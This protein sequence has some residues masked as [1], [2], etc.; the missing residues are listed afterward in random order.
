MGT[1]KRFNLVSFL[2]AL[3]ITVAGYAVWKTHFA[4]SRARAKVL[5]RSAAPMIL[6]H[7]VDTET[8]GNYERYKATQQLLA[9]SRF[10]L[11]TALQNSRVS[12]YRMVREQSDPIAWLQDKLE[13]EFLADSEVMEIS[14]Q[15]DDPAELAGLVNAVTRAYL[16]EVANEDLKHRAQ[17]HALLT[18]LRDRYAET[19]KERRETLRKCS[20]TVAS[21][22]RL[23]ATGLDRPALLRLQHDLMT[24]LINLH[25]ERARTEARLAQ[26][27]KAVG[28]AT[29][30]V[31]N[32]ID[33]I[34]GLLA[35]LV[36][37][38]KFI[39]DELQRLAGETQQAADQ[40]PQQERLKAD[41][42][43]MEDIYRKIA[44]EVE[45]LSLELQAPPRFSLIEEAVPPRG[46]DGITIGGL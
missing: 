11:N 27:K 41:I 38:E 20:Q 6:F 2:L 34:E 8:G 43:L 23:R 9:K 46:E 40:E 15:G 14:L 19:L 4:K 18:K 45:A 26:R 33:Q 28:L 12:K 10:V 17:R 39:A 31:R 24:Q 3:T 36:A 32:E 7:T 42:A 1:W 29:D 44:A 21:D 16:E 30:P 25:L 37:Q 13:I 22:D 35:G 5:V